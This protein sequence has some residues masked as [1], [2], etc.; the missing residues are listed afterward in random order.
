[1]PIRRLDLCQ[2][3]RDLYW[4]SYALTAHGR[5]ESLGVEQT[6]GMLKHSAVVLKLRRVRIS[7][8]ELCFTQLFLEP[9]FCNG[10]TLK[11]PSG[12]G[13]F[14][15]PLYVQYQWPRRQP[16]LIWHECGAD[17]AAWHSC[18]LSWGMFTGRNRGGGG[19]GGGAGS[20]PQV[21]TSSHTI[22]S[23]VGIQALFYQGLV[24]LRTVRTK[25]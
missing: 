17:R 5:M 3:E 16:S 1:V 13:A 14:L 20:L 6:K 4:S 9:I 10:L 18:A 8:S 7:T 2:A 21:L 23:T 25:A 24:D 11:G 22:Q 19:G 15:E 12:P